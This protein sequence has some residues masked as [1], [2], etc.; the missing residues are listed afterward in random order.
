MKKET[1]VIKT[2]KGFI[3]KVN[4]IVESPYTQNIDDAERL[5]ELD[6]KIKSTNFIGRRPRIVEVAF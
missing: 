3:K 4:S 6:A 5:S 2:D 1:Y